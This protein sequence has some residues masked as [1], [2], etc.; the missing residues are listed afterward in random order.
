MRMVVLLGSPAV[1]LPVG[2]TLLLARSISVCA[3][4]FCKHHTLGCRSGAHMHPS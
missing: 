4:Q 2:I 1:A 3:V